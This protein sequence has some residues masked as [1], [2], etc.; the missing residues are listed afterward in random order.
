MS[1]NNIMTYHAPV[2]RAPAA[3]LRAQVEYFAGH[4]LLRQMFD[5]VPDVF[6]V[7][8]P[9]RLCLQTPLKL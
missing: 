7:H 6:L 3:V 5:A 4:P 2:E 8:N 1:L 9:E